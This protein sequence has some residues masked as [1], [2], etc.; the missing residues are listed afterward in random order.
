M[1]GARSGTSQ[2]MFASGLTEAALLFWRLKKSCDAYMW[3]RVR[4][5][6][7]GREEESHMTAKLACS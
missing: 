3:G 4:A 5:G 1:G 6:T 2:L 7:R